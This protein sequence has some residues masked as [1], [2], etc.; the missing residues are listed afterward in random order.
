MSPRKKLGLTLNFS[1]P[2][3]GTPQDVPSPRGFLSPRRTPAST[4]YKAPGSHR[5]THGLESPPPFRLTDSA[6]E[7]TAAESVRKEAHQNSVQRQ[8]ETA[9]RDAF[10]HHTSFRRD[11]AYKDSQN[12]P[13]FRLS[14]EVAH[15]H[16]VLDFS[17]L[18]HAKEVRKQLNR[19][20]KLTR[21]DLCPD[22]E[23]HKTARE[24]GKVLAGLVSLLGDSLSVQQRKPQ[25]I[26]QPQVDQALQSLLDQLQQE[27]RLLAPLCKSGR[28][29]ELRSL[30]VEIPRD[31]RLVEMMATSALKKDLFNAWTNVGLDVRDLARGELGALTLEDLDSA[32]PGGLSSPGAVADARQVLA[33]RMCFPHMDKARF[34]ALAPVLLERQVPLELLQCMAG[35][36]CTVSWLRAMASSFSWPPSLCAA[37]AWR[38]S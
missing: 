7:D 8:V 13:A 14:E 6:T 36:P 38:L 35:W 22:Q 33:A 18:P 16:V 24:V 31:S 19:Y 37:A 11:I 9:T 23:P 1:T 34:L 27:Q 2:P 28:I 10:Q 15:G 4:P 25:A 17:H 20:V 3:G 5:P 30:G 29:K 21:V 12:K 26:Q 32:V